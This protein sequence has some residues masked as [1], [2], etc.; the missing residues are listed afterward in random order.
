MMYRLSDPDRLAED[1][2]A[3]AV[4][5]HRWRR[6][7]RAGVALKAGAVLPIV[8]VI[9]ASSARL[10]HDSFIR[11]DIR[12]VGFFVSLLGALLAA[13]ATVL[14]LVAAKDD[15]HR[16]VG[17]TT[18]VSGILAIGWSLVGAVAC[19]LSDGLPSLR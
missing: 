19:V 11:D 8:G 1:E 14:G 6:V 5:E 13:V 4:A 7:R 16:P 15:E 9:V 17:V 3:M 12:E 10:S 2:R 18:A